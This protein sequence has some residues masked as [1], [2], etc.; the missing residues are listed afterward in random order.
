[1]PT[2]RAGLAASEEMEVCR[3]HRDPEAGEAAQNPRIL[4]RRENLLLGAAQGA[5][6]ILCRPHCSSMRRRPRVQVAI[7]RQPVIPAP[8][9]ALVASERSWTLSSSLSIPGSQWQSF[10]LRL[11]GRRNSAGGPGRRPMQ[12]A[13]DTLSRTRR[14]ARRAKLRRLRP[15]SP[16][17]AMASSAS[18]GPQ[19]N[20]SCVQ[21]GRCWELRPSGVGGPHSRRGI[22]TRNSTHSCN[23]SWPHRS[24]AAAGANPSGAG[25]LASP[26]GAESPR[27]YARCLPLSPSRGLEQSPRPL[28]PLC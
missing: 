22:A 20:A 27:G 23:A 5:P 17:R 7:A 24:L 12:V 11:L 21:S 19:W 10:Q 15:G 26:L 9:L 4:A 18:R 2:S 13:Q 16:W 6:A 3:L 1:M 28:V 8:L 25:S 14:S